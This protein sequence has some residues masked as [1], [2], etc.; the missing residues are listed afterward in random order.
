L[1]THGSLI[2]Y[3]TAHDS[4]ALHS[5][6]LEAIQQLQE[7]CDNSS[8]ITHQL[9]PKLYEPVGSIFGACHTGGFVPLPCDDTFVLA[10]AVRVKAIHLAQMAPR[11]M[12]QVSSCFCAGTSTKQH[13]STCGAAGNH[14][15]ATGQACS[16]GSASRCDQQLLAASAGGFLEAVHGVKDYLRCKQVQQWVV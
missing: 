6:E 2:K 9:V 15:K 4:V 3:I 8:V 13:Q 11:L 1:Q 7:L 10:M 14:Q 5:A 16:E 12:D